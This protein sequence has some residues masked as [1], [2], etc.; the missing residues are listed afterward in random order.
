[1]SESEM[2]RYAEEHP[3]RVNEQDDDGWT[4][5]SVA[6]LHRA[7]L[8]MITWLIDE[9]GADINGRSSGGHTAIFYASLE[10]LSFLLERGADPTVQSSEGR[11][12]LVEHSLFVQPH[13][14]E[15]L[16]QDNRTLG[17][18]WFDERLHGSSYGLLHL[19]Q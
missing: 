16:L 14:V 6:A 8:D 17:I 3:E 18:S 19:G 7:S 11:T 10:V 12:A 1:M 5:L 13:S 15:R 4:L 9:K 2:R